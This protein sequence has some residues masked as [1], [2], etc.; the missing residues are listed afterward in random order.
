MG[1]G[2]W[3]K[4]SRHD[5]CA[6]V[7][8]HPQLD[9]Q[10]FQPFPKLESAFATVEVGGQVLPVQLSYSWYFLL[11]RLW[12][13]VCQN[14]RLG[15][16]DAVTMAST[17]AGNL[18]ATN[19]ATGQP[20]QNVLTGT[21]VDSLIAEVLELGIPPEPLPAAVASGPDLGLLELLVPESPASGPGVAEIDLRLLELGIPADSLTVDLPLELVLPVDPP[22]EDL[23]PVM[24]S[25]L[26]SIAL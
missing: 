12:Q 10:N 13:I 4:D 25:D 7:S 24:I 6:R 2:S 5:W 19:V 11:I 1:P 23:L 9:H 20:V 26:G 15:Y 14:G 16:Q 17:G 22:P 8:D 21:T 18:T 3:P